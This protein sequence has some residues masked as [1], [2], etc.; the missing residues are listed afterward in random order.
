MYQTA[1]CHF[2]PFDLIII[3]TSFNVASIV[4][5]FYYVI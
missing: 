1:G 5:S 4:I 3:V 2:V